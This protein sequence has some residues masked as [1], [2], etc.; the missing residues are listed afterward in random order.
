MIVLNQTDKPYLDSVGWVSETNYL[1]RKRKTP[2]IIPSVRHHWSIGEAR[3]LENKSADYKIN[4]VYCL[5]TP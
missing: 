3:A 2:Q 1:Q 5:H 4:L